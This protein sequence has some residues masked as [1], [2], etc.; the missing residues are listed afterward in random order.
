VQPVTDSGLSQRLAERVGTYLRRETDGTF[1]AIAT[2]GW[3]AVPLPAAAH[4]NDEQ[5]RALAAAAGAAGTRLWSVALEPLE[6]IAPVFAIEPTTDDLR[7]FNRRLGFVNA[8]LIATDADAADARWIVGCSTDDVLV[9][10]G[11]SE[12]LAPLIGG[13]PERA[14]AAFAEYANDPAWRPETRALLQRVAAAL[15]GYAGAPA[16]T[17]LALGA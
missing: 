11:P 16:G 13:T 8:A 2:P 17:A 3:S 1:V 5:R 15:A 12:A 7:L 4:L 10:L 6:G 9:A 14:F